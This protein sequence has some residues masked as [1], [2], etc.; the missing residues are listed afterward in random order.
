VQADDCFGV[1]R[2]AGIGAIAHA[3][4]A[5]WFARPGP[6]ARLTPSKEIAMTKPEIGKQDTPPPGPKVEHSQVKHK[7][8]QHDAPAH[9]EWKVDEAIDESFP[10]SDAPAETQ[11]KPTREKIGEKGGNKNRQK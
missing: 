3:E 4:R 10:A 11:P 8:P 1:I 9:T 6:L 2:A 5:A 7:P